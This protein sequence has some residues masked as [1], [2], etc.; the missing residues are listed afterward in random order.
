MSKTNIRA[1][2]QAPVQSRIENEVG[3]TVLPESHG[4]GD[5]GNLH[6]KKTIEEKNFRPSRV[7]PSRR[8]Q[9]S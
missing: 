8:D 1:H 3:T 2:A 5:R 7:Y 4:V 6:G 9:P